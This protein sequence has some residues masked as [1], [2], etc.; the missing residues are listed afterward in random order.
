M[1]SHTTR[2]KPHPRESIAS[3]ELDANSFDD[4][5]ESPADWER[6][7][8][9]LPLGKFDD[10][11]KAFGKVDTR[12]KTYQFWHRVVTYIVAW[13]APIAVI[14][15]VVGLGHEKLSHV[16]TVPDESWLNGLEVWAAGVAIVAVAIGWRAGFKKKWLINRHKAELHR[17]LRYRF[18]IHPSLWKGSEGGE[19]WL[20]ENLHEI[21]SLK[22]KHA[23][24][25]ATNEPPAHGPFEAQ[26]RLARNRIE[27]LTRYYLAKRLN[28]Q[29]EY[30]ANRAQ[31][32]EI[33]DWARSILPGFFFASIVAVVFK[34]GAAYLAGRFPRTAMPRAT[35]IAILCAAL[36]P[37]VAAGVRTYLAA[38]EFSRNKSRFNAA[39]EALRQLEKSLLDH[40][41]AAIT[42]ESL[43]VAPDDSEADASAVLR[44]LY[45]CEHILD[46]EH[47]EWLRLMYD[48]EWFG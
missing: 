2:H 3:G 47:R 6:Y 30:F 32:N 46:S 24:E 42:S 17:L 44:D 41:L 35:A 40:M 37:I 34:S 19:K 23:L 45:W 39:H 4:M 11:V 16:F 7:H 9:L 26:S 20:G 43:L 12:A 48:A 14:S 29:K 36:L 1:A 8:H 18:L 38:F 22:G 31:R 28:P 21:A 15:A 27:A 10:V 25:K 33:K 5:H 13:A